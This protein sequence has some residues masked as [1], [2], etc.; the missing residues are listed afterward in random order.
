MAQSTVSTRFAEISN[1]I[2]IHLAEEWIVF[3][4]VVADIQRKKARFLEAT[5]FPNTIGAVDCTHVAMIA[6]SEEEHNYLNRKGFHSKNVQ[7]ICDYDLRIMNVNAR[8][9]GATHDAYIW[10]NSEINAEME[11]R[12]I[13]GDHNTWCIADS[14]YP[15]QPWLM[16]PIANA[17]PDTPEGRYTAAL[18][19][20]RSCI[21]R[22]IGVL[23][24]RF[25]C[26]LGE[27]ML[28]YT[29]QVVAQGR[30]LINQNVN[31]EV[32]AYFYNADVM[33]DENVYLTGSL[34]RRRC[35]ETYFM[36]NV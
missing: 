32:E 1:L 22:C 23:K 28:H 33:Q 9:A 6:P 17:L 25:R 36:D 16:I 7:I 35:I 12:Y 21:E 3:P 27:R 24:G 13:E 5:M 2:C 10:R 18:C 20:A 26:I 15:Q 14:G 34:A 31:E 30:L 11:R 4:T 29:P 19:Q 8:Y